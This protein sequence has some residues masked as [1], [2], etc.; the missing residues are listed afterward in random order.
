M[1]K[2]I[3]NKD[4]NN[5]QNNIK[6]KVKFSNILN[7][8]D[9]KRKPLY[10]NEKTINNNFTI[11]MIDKPLYKKKKKINK[12]F[13]YSSLATKFNNLK[14]ID[15]YTNKDITTI[16]RPK[17]KYCTSKTG[18]IYKN[19][20]MYTN[21]IKPLLN[22]VLSLNNK[23]KIYDN[24]E[25]KKK[26]EPQIIFNKKVKL[27]RNDLYIEIY[28]LTKQLSLCDY[29]KGIKLNLANE[30]YIQRLKELFKEKQLK[31]INIISKKNNELNADKNIEK[32]EDEKL[33]KE[34]KKKL[35]DIIKELNSEKEHI[36][37]LYQIDYKLIKK[38]ENIEIEK[39]VNNNLIEKLKN[40]L[41]NIFGN[42]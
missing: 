22:P 16:K 31:Y 25:P 28:K 12:S 42:H 39:I 34:K 32:S 11:I 30:T 37:A 18:I 3:K 24:K 15:S 36:K 26:I 20:K 2:E 17:K 4:I 19:K 33:S 35:E 8:L 40:R 21:F 6:N 13:D 5:I 14:K 1:K 29:N 27:L 38:R 41:F 23:K 10:I 9:N 7:N